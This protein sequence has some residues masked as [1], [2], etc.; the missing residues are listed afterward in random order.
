MNMPPPRLPRRR[1]A[2]LAVAAALLCAAASSAQRPRV[3]RAFAGSTPVIDGVIEPGEWDDAFVWEGLADWDPQFAPIAPG[4]PVDLDARIRVKRDN[5]SLF[6]AFE[7]S[8]DILYRTQTPPFLPGGNPSANNLTQAGW[9]WFGDEF[10]LMI[11]ANNSWSNANET[12]AG[13]DGR[14]WQM[15][16]NAQKSRIG[17]IGVG[18]LLEGEPRSS[19]AAWANY[20]AWI[21]GGA[22]RAATNSA[23]GAGGYGGSALVAE[24]AIDFDPCV[25]LAEGVFYSPAAAAGSAVTV[26]F[27]IAI[28]DVDEPST[29][30]P[31]Y[32]LH[33]EM[34]LSGRTCAYMNCHTAKS[35]F[36]TLVL[37][38]GPRP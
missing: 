24:V 15:V 5:A 38:P 25:E 7:I 37:E 3:L 23:P 11:N 32:G 20:G 35:E 31:T 28:G 36:G 13:V 8:D 21:R 18:G 19:D 27:N 14:A 4:A 12:V 2:R 6:F 9:P 17:G 33:H 29:S 26:G 30:D 16:V 34:W 22:M 10:E 1:G